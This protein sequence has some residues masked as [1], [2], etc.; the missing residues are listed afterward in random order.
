MIRKITK[1]IS[2]HS[3]LTI[4]ISV[5]LLILVNPYYWETP[6]RDYFNFLFLVLILLSAILTIKKSRTNLKYL[7]GI[8]YLLIGISLLSALKIH[9]FFE[10]LEKLA[11]VLYLVLVAINLVMEMIKSR[12]VDSEVILSAVAAYV[13]FG[14]CGA[15]VTAVI[16]FF[17]PA[18]FTIEATDISILHQCLY[19][20]FVT[21]TTTG[22]GDIAPIAPIA[23]TLAIYL[24]VFGQLYLTVIISILI[25]KYLSSRSKS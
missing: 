12:E 24:A 23:K 10:L 20:S 18:A 13:L 19:F 16:L 25:G 2:T 3:Q 8:G 6:L 5:L 22:Y 15:L 1:Y 17:E 7:A 4:I 21:I 11:Y 14:F 9:P